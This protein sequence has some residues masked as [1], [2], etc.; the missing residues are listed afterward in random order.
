MSDTSNICENCDEPLN[1]TEIA[2]KRK[3]GNPAWACAECYEPMADDGV[4]D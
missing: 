1:E 4:I 3:A 2:S